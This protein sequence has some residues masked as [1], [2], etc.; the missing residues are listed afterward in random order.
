MDKS[1]K[2]HQFMKN[3]PRNIIYST[4]YVTPFGTS[5]E[6][7]GGISQPYKVAAVKSV[8]NSFGQLAN[9]TPHKLLF[10]LTA[11]G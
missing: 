11:S 3:T 1:E 9:T 5:F 8:A 4:T 10:A 6:H 7:N 2:R